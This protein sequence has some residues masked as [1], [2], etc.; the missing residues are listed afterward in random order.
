MLPQGHTHEFLPT[1]RLRAQ[2]NRKALRDDRRIIA[3]HRAAFANL[4]LDSRERTL[5]LHGQT[6]GVLS[7][8][9]ANGLCRDVFSTHP[10]QGEDNPLPGVRFQR[11]LPGLSKDRNLQECPWR[12]LGFRRAEI[13]RNDN[14]TDTL[15]GTIVPTYNPD[16]PNQ[17]LRA[18]VPRSP[19]GLF[20][21]FRLSNRVKQ[22]REVLAGDASPK[23]CN[24]GKPLCVCCLIL[25]LLE[26]DLL[27]FF[28]QQHDTHFKLTAFN[29]GC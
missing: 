8:L 28:R 16:C 7:V 17:H 10:L 1:I 25:P 27:L 2:Q 24:R 3:D 14:A 15:V 6:D 23:G 20:C 26:K 21:L 12:S 18:R 9:Q 4:S 22:F 19:L 11:L 5:I 29:L 13:I